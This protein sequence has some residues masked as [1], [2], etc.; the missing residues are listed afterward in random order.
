[1]E[2]HTNIERLGKNDRDAAI[3]AQS[4]SF[5]HY[6]G[7]RHALRA[8]APRRGRLAGSAVAAISTVVV[9]SLLAPA[10]TA[11]QTPPD[12]LGQTYLRAVEAVLAQNATDE[13]IERLT[14]LYSV[15]VVYEHP[16]AGVRIRGRDRIAEAMAEF[17]GQTRNPDTDVHGST[18]GE[19]VV[20]L[21]FTLEMERE[22][23]LGWRPLERRQVTVL[24]VNAQGRISRILEYW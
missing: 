9:A 4:A 1:M 22:T 3:D 13:D 11:A 17:L 16:R 12:G 18:Q 5:Y 20:V 24:E 7:M 8:G 19:G 6:T 10:A 15:D 23:E 14:F 21:D 2:R